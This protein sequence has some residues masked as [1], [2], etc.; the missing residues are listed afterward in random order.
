V[1]IARFSTGSDPRFGIV[2]GDELVVLAGDP[3]FSGFETLDERVPLSGVRLLAPVIPR[4]KVVAFGRTY[5]SSPTLGPLLFVKPNTTV[6]G[7]G[8]PIRLPAGAGPVSAGGT[9]VAII[10]RIAKNVKA[11]DAL[12]FVFGYT[13][14]N[15]VTATDFS[16][17]QPAQSKAYDS[18]APIGPVIET[19]LDP[20]GLTITTRIDGEVVASGSTSRMLRTVGELVELASSVFTLLPGDVIMT[21][22][23]AVA[24]AP[25]ADGDVVEVEIEGIG[26]L[27]NPAR[28]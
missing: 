11:A 2:D 25:L 4:S 8:E 10:G 7:P 3:M 16:A 18:F 21:G 12:D 5:D 26:R 28:A 24:D 20:R 19:E 15:D 1:K 6:V 9:L 14:G 23:P 22:A 13:V 27:V 17:D